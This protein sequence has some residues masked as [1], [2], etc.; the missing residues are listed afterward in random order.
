[1][2]GIH[3][4]TIGYSNRYNIKPIFQH[5]MKKDHIL[6]W[7]MIKFKRPKKEWA[8]GA[9]ENRKEDIAKAFINN[10]TVT[11]VSSKLKIPITYSYKA[12]KKKKM[13]S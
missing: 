9:L 10:V 12:K 7:F 6:I 2:I 8:E 5:N 13:G 4:Y 11:K 3:L 1:M